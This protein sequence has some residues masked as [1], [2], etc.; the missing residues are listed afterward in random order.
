[1]KTPQLLSV[2]ALAPRRIIWIRINRMLAWALIVA[3][4]THWA[5][6]SAAIK[7]LA[8]ELAIFL[9]HAVLSLALFGFPKA[10]KGKT[11]VA[12]LLLGRRPPGQDA[13]NRFLLDGYRIGLTALVLVPM[14]HYLA[15]G[16]ALA[17]APAFLGLPVVA[18]MMIAVMVVILWPLF[19]TPL[20]LVQH[21]YPAILRALQRWGVRDGA[22]ALATLIVAY[23]FILCALNLFN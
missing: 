9:A 17:A 5:L 10:M 4:F 18:L 20:T 2:G 21:L 15:V 16:L 1:M 22:C 12:M 19:R 11:A 3:P 13:H 8:F 7:S 23:F 6:G 14:A